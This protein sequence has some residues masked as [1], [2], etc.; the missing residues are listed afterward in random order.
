MKE[1]ALHIQDIAE[2]SVRAGAGLL[3]IEIREETRAD[4]VTVVIEDDGHGMDDDT[5]R[6]A[7]NPFFTTK[8][9]RRI[10]M[11]LSMFKQA[12]LQ[13]D[14]RFDVDSAPGRGTRVEA[15]FR[16]TH[17]DRQP[18]GN[19]AATIVALLMSNP[20]MD[21]LYRHVRDE[22]V[23]VFDTRVIR[24]TLEDVPISEPGVLQ[25]VRELIS[26]RQNLDE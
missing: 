2:N 12:A 11:G 24:Q 15:S 26:A 9:V 18:L 3:V 7:L 20:D 17:M 13:A 22:D 5:V 21:I 23:F 25:F 16:L 1:I 8:T 6:K 4:L 19:M 10:G 14:G